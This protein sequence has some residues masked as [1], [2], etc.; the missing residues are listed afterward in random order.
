MTSTHAGAD[1]RMLDPDQLGERSADHA[2]T[3]FS[4]RR[5]KCRCLS[6]RAYAHLAAVEYNMH[7][8]V[9][10]RGSG[11]FLHVQIGKAT[12]GCISLHRPALVH[13]LRWLDPHALPQIAIGTT[14]S[15]RQSRRG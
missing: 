7:P 2:D 4:T 15:L 1:D 5:P 9:P 8:V 11:I 13:V 12:S 3:F 14:G 6:P 10:G